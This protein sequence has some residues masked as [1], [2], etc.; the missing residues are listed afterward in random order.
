MKL[1]VGK[2]VIG[3]EEDFDELFSFI[4]Q[5][6]PDE[7]SEWSEEF[8][9]ELSHDLAFEFTIPYGYQYRVKEE[10]YSDEG[11]RTTVKVEGEKAEKSLICEG[12]MLSSERIDYINE[13]IAAVQTVDEPSDAPSIYIMLLGIGIVIILVILRLKRKLE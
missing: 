9:F 10:D 12:T 7:A 5:V 3:S 4:I 13:K 1:E 8:A 2:T 11:Y 6:R